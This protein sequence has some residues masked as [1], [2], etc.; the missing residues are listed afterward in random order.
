MR[1]RTDRPERQCSALCL[2]KPENDCSIG[3]KVVDLELT[4]KIAWSLLPK[5][6]VFNSE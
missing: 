6:S 1:N 4:F 5:L 2:L 3:A